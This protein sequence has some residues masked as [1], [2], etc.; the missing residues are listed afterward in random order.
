MERKCQFVAM[1][2]TGEKPDGELHMLAFK[3]N[4]GRACCGQSS[5]DLGSIMAAVCAAVQGT[6]KSIKEQGGLMG[7]SDFVMRIM[8]ALTKGVGTE[9]LAFLVGSLGAMIAGEK[10]DE[11]DCDAESV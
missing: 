10:D 1:V 11:E 6:G 4:G 8:D 7:A 2:N 5:G 3:E 9:A